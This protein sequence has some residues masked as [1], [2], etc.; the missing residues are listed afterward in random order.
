MDMFSFN[1]FEF[2]Q[3]V[4]TASNALSGLNHVS[5]FGG[6]AV[7]AIGTHAQTVSIKDLVGVKGGTFSGSKEGGH[8]LF[9]VGLVFVNLILLFY[10]F[11]KNAKK[12][13]NFTC[14]QFFWKYYIMLAFS[15]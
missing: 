11:Y 6:S 2:R 1:H 7:Q 8:F 13:F 5:E 15:I 3:V 10:V 4:A 14:G 9:V 12:E